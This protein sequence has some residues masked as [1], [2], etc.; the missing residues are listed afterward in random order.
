MF[1]MDVKQEVNQSIYIMILG[2]CKCK[3]TL[4]EASNSRFA[5]NHMKTILWVSFLKLFREFTVHT[6]PQHYNTPTITQIS[7]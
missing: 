5:L 4:I 2:T 3:Q 6:G 1:T 7:I